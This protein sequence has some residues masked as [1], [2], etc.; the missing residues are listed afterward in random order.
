[1]CPDCWKR[2]LQ[3]QWLLERKRIQLYHSGWVSC[4]QELPLHSLV[5]A[6]SRRVRLR[7][8]AE[9]D[10]FHARSR[11]DPRLEVLPRRFQR[12]RAF[13]FIA[14]MA[15]GVGDGLA[16]IGGE[17]KQPAVDLVEAGLQ[18]GDGPISRQD[19]PFRAEALDAMQG[20][21]AACLT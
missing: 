8:A 3:R 19:R 1:M 17:A 9:S 14:A 7:Y 12:H 13:R 4:P 15:I 18:A 20:G 11:R 5:V 2:V 21:R 16:E 6:I 10:H